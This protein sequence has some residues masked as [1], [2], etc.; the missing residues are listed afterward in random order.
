M[1]IDAYRYVDIMYSINFTYSNNKTAEYRLK[2]PTRL[3]KPTSQSLEFKSGT[4]KSIT[5]C[6]KNT[7]GSSRLVGLLIVL[8][9]NN[10]TLFGSCHEHIHEVD[11]FSNYVFGYVLA[12]MDQYLNGF[13][14]V[15][16]E[17]CPI[18]NQVTSCGDSDH[19][20]LPS[21]KFYDDL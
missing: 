1:R 10:S 7:N 12:K 16:Y 3:N 15:W 17:I 6:Y 5:Q 4:I 20:T 18:N 21:S 14:F 19:Y 8:N 11:K 13:Q 2:N 9:N